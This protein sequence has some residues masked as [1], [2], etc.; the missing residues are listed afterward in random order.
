MSHLATSISV[1][2]VW[3]HDRVKLLSLELWLRSFQCTEQ[4]NAPRYKNAL[5]T[6]IF[7]I[8]EG[9]DSINITKHFK[10]M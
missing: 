8:K 4:K 7:G 9:F 10:Q 5:S 3:V 2:A 6:D 1:E